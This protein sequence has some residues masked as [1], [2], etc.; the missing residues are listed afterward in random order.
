MRK[1]LKIQQKYFNIFIQ[2]TLTSEELCVVNIVLLSRRGSF[3]F[4]FQIQKIALT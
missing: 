3:L 4:P 1:I 2:R